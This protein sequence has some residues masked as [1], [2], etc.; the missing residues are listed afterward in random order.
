VWLQLFELARACRAVVC[1]R[2]APLQ[3][4]GVVELIK[5]KAKEMTLAIGDGTHTKPLCAPGVCPALCTPGWAPLCPVS[6]SG[7]PGRVSEMR[8]LRCRTASVLAA[9][10]HMFHWPMY[11][12]SSAMKAPEVHL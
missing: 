8:L 7:R 3:K 9:M 6:Q 11:L 2:V 12:E 4:A 1:C 10:L 5:R